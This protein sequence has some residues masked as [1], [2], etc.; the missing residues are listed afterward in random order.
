MMNIPQVSDFEKSIN[1]K[2]TT[3][4]ALKNSNGVEVFLTNYGARIVSV[5]VP[6][7]DGNKVDVNLGFN[8]ID[9]YTKVNSNYYGAVIG[10]VCGRIRD[11]EF[12]IDEKTYELQPNDNENFLHGGKKGFHTQIFEVEKKAEQAVEF[13]YVSEYGEEGF[14]GNLSFKIEY[15]LTEENELKL[16]FQAETDKKTPFNVTHHA[17][18][19]LNGEGSGDV[20]AHKLQVFSD[21]FLPIK[22]DVLPTGKIEKVEGTPFDFTQAK[23]IGADINSSDQQVQYGNGYD[24]T[25]VL[26][27]EFSS[28]VKHAAQ[29]K[30]NKTGISLDVYTDQPGIHLYSGNFMDGSFTLKSGK[31]D[32]FRNAFCLETQHLAD[33]L[34]NPD[35]PSIILGPN[36]IFKSHTIFKFSTDKKTE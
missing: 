8:H 7:K 23:R 2:K 24:H 16:N 32:E 26:S 4:V 36:N 34:N 35:F 14:P 3:L 19:N 31:K 10:R 9:D 13:S 21:E 11:S 15:K 12:R 17:F 18:F 33:A 29:A 6:D 22:A 27:E 20:L 1:G 25:F 5:L 30:S 28:E